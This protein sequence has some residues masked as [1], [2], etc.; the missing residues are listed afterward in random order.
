MSK[1]VEQM[2]GLEAID[3]LVDALEI[4]S[5]LEFGE[6]SDDDDMKA[7]AEEYGM[8]GLPRDADGEPI[9][10]GDLMA[11]GDDQAFYVEEMH[12]VA[13]DK[14]GCMWQV[15]NNA[16]SLV[17]SD[18]L[19]HVPEDTIEG[20]LIEA[21]MRAHCDTLADKDGTDVTD[22]LERLRELMGD[23]DER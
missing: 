15:S 11:L 13:S 21:V 5:M 19:H 20:I 14:D 2:T 18:M 23:S 22:L 16:G 12:L 3:T 9:H 8:V 4:L 6:E 1:R 7:C 17:K 10:I